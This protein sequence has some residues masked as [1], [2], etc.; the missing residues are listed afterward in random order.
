MFYIS[1]SDE[2]NSRLRTKKSWRIAFWFWFWGMQHFFLGNHPLLFPECWQRM[3]R[4]SPDQKWARLSAYL[5]F[6]QWFSDSMEQLSRLN[7]HRNFLIFM[8]AHWDL[9]GILRLLLVV[10]IQ[11]MDWKLKSY[12]MILENGFKQLIIPFQIRIGEYIGQ[13]LMAFKCHL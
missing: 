4:V 1:V 10:I 13:F 3:S 9:I 8:S 12:F 7:H 11:L 6:S 5:R 2:P